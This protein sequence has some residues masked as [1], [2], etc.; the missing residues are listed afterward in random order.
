MQK[1]RRFLTHICRSISTLQCSSGGYRPFRMLGKELGYEIPADQ[2]QYNADY[3]ETDQKD[4]C[5]LYLR[6]K[7]L[8]TAE[9]IKY[10]G[11]TITNDLKWNTYVSNICLKTNRTLGFLRLYLAACH[12]TLKSRHTWDCCVQSWSMVVQCGT[13]KAYLNKMNLRRKKGS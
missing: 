2:M 3:K 13:P 9:K 4:H 10:L 1:Y 8:D 11:T 5:F 6:G 12:R 7:V